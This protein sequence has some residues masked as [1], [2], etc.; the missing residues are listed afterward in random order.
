MQSMR[1]G[2]A[3]DGAKP[4]TIGD[5]AVLGLVATAAA[6]ALSIARSKTAALVLGPTG[7]GI[8]AEILQLVTLAQAPAAIFSGAALVSR[9]SASRAADDENSIARLY[10]GAW[11]LS[12]LVASAAGAVA[13]AAGFFVLP[14]PWGQS[15]WPYTALAAAGGALAVVAAI[16]SQVLVVFGKL[17][18]L[19]SLGVA[20][21]FIQTLLVVGATIALGLTGQFVA[22]AVGPLL[23][24]WLALAMASRALPGFHW[25][26]RAVLDLSFAREAFSYGAASLAALLGLQAALFVVRLSLDRK[27]G[28]DLNGQFQV[29][30]ALGSVY[31][32][33]ILNSIGTYSF[34][35]FAG[36][37]SEEELAVEVAKASRFVLRVAPPVV[38]G[39]IALRAP[40]VHL[41]YSSRFEEA[42]P[43][44][45]LMMVGDVARALVWVQ[46]G[47]L[48]YRGH[49]AAYL[50]VEMLGVAGLGLGGALLI[51]YFGLE[52]FGY[53]YSA[54]YLLLV[55]ISALALRLS[56]RVAV[57][58]R[59]TLLA[60]ATTVLLGGGAL[61]GSSTLLGASIV[62]LVA[63]AWAYASGLLRGIGV[64]LASFLS[65]RAARL[66]EP[67]DPASCSLP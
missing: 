9:L 10:S 67:D 13:V 24:I 5:A 58:W 7:I 16:P 23:G 46:H 33:F 56:T 17:R 35:R 59:P 41:L 50:L 19:T 49:L 15:A 27:G 62:I 61:V 30:W 44:M 39:M 11:I 21:S 38:L 20:N 22:I 52:G 18:A 31:F 29:A 43:L 64:R 1:P 34:P 14:G 6:I 36:A 66:A 53:A 32:G 40:L 65:K 4:V 60:L 28:P 26:P 54:T 57:G 55:P 51:P 42:V 25:R 37:R 47:P 48:L 3:S 12:A 63:L 2:V 8:T 45:G